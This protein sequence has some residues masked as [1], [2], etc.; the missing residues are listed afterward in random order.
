MY[1]SRSIS[2]MVKNS[3]GLLSAS[4]QMRIEVIRGRQ[5]TCHSPEGMRQNPPIPVREAFVVPIHI[6]KLVRISRRGD[7]REAR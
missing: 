1:T 5:Q 6:G 2:F 7:G 4:M 3:V